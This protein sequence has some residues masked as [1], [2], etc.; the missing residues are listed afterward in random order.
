MDNFL[1]AWIFISVVTFG[2]GLYK[3]GYCR[4]RIDML[5]E[6]LHKTVEGFKKERT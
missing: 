5:D 4:G 6:W 1:Y 3:L 2:V